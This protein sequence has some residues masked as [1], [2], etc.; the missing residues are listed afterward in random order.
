MAVSVG[1]R[2]QKGIFSKMLPIARLTGCSSL[3]PQTYSGSVAS[4]DASGHVHRGDCQ[5]RHRGIGG[6]RMSRDQFSPARLSAKYL[7]P[8]HPRNPEQLMLN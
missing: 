7:A 6:R 5:E 2:G 4:V 1:R 3:L 8:M